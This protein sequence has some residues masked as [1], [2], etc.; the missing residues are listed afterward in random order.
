MVASGIRTAYRFG[1]TSIKV[2]IQDP[3][4]AQWLVEF[5]SPWFSTEEPAGTGL[6]VKVIN[7]REQFSALARREKEGELQ[8]LPCFGLDS[9]LVSLPGWMESD[10]ATLVADKELCCYYR[11]HGNQVEVIS[12]PQERQARIGL[13]RV[14]R[15]LA[16]SGASS[17]SDVL[18]LHA[19]AFVL[20]GQAILLAGDKKSGKT[21]LLAHA[22]TSRHTAL[23][24]NDRIIIEGN[25][26][27]AYGVPT[28]V[29][30][31]EGTE[32][33]F[34][35]LGNISPRRAFIFHE[36]ELTSADPVGAG[37][38]K[39]LALSLAQFGKQ[40]NS[41]VESRAPVG[42]ILF[43]RVSSSVSTLSLDPLDPSEAAAYLHRCI[44]GSRS[45]T[46]D[47]TVFQEMTRSPQITGACD[48]LIT[49]L[50]IAV[51]V[52]RCVLGAKAYDESADAL[53]KILRTD[54][55]AFRQ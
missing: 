3:D 29:S 9:M 20:G 39:P 15:E 11:L 33:I 23:M 53:L 17:Q 49:Q 46:R 19:A 44:Y 27:L 25:R 5:L 24:A 21:T 8:H 45:G 43:P 13:M 7:S 12:R 18:D 1:A 30:V 16:T 52:F 32:Q 51:P 55:G 41:P 37:S 14:L 54:S 50:A 22:L 42:A 36:R 6:L 26:F 31:R 34:P 4:V 35:Q 47:T 38:Q 10:G 40:M 48:S 2:D 28:I